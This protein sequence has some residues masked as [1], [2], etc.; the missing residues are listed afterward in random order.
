MAAL[1]D[2]SRPGREPV[3]TDEARTFIVDPACRKAKDFGYPHELWTTRL[4]TGHIR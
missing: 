3:I 1:D 2:S 4:L